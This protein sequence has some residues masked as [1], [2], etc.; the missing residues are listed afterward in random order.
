MPIYG[1]VARPAPNGGY[2]KSSL[3]NAWSADV[4]AA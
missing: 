3:D 4:S 1:R 2:L